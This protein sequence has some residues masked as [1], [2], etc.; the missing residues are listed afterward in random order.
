MSFPSP[1]RSFSNS[2]LF[3]TRPRSILSLCPFDPILPFILLPLLPLLPFFLLPD[4]AVNLFTFLLLLVSRRCVCARRSKSDSI[5]CVGVISAAV[6]G[7]G[8]RHSLDRH[9]PGI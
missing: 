8:L 7:R 2:S 5:R 1:P 3:L 6:G 9:A 4:A